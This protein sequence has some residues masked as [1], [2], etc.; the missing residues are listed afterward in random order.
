MFPRP[1]EGGVGGRIHPDMDLSDLSDDERAW[2]KR[3]PYIGGLL[4]TAVSYSVPK[5]YGGLHQWAGNRP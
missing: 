2:L 1:G 5:S 3:H 4:L